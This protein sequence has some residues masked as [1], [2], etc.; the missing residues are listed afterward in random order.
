MEPPLV[1]RIDYGFAVVSAVTA[2]SAGGKQGGGSFTV[3]ELYESYFDYRRSYEPKEA[4]DDVADW[5]AFKASLTA[6]YK[7]PK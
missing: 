1:D 6:T 7:T 3:K 5:D 2:N 4:I